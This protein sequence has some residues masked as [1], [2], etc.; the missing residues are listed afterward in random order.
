[1]FYFPGRTWYTQVTTALSNLQNTVNTMAGKVNQ[2]L[3]T[4]QQISTGIDTVN[5]SLDDLKTKTGQLVDD[6]KEI[7]GEL[8]AGQPLSQATIDKFNAMV[9]SAQSV[10]AALDPAVDAV[11]ALANSQPPAQPT[12]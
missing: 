6:A 11:S 12:A 2:V 4:E 8:Q 9:S 7:Q 3:M 1:V 10:Q 5:A